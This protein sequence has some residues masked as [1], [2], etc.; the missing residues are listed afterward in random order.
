MQKTNSWILCCL[1][2][3]L[4]SPSRADVILNPTYVDSAAG[5]WNATRIAVFDQ[6]ISDWQS[7][8]S[9][10]DDGM[11][12]TMSVTIDFTA[13]F[14]NVANGYLG[15]WEGSGSFSSG[16]DIRP[17]SPGVSHT[18]RMNNFYDTGANTLWY[19]PTP[20][21][22]GSDKAFADW[23]ALTVARHEIGHLLGFTGFFVDD[24]NT[25]SESSPWTALIDGSNVFDPGGLNVA[26]E[27]GD[28]AHVLDDGLLMD[29]ALSNAE[30]RIAISAT[31]SQMLALAYGYQLN[32]VPE[33][34]ALAVV[35]CLATFA[36]VRRRQRF[37]EAK[38]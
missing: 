1:I 13:T 8:F 35:G 16:T 10:V 28:P 36:F 11:G 12:G 17:W 25:G 23:D 2:G 29:V 6:A 26:M 30:G 7:I 20:S 5:S 22:D 18:I 24:F 34:S 19:D 38:R 4:A 37:C 33:P 14:S 9:G 3:L 31:E 32:A 27:P 15:Q 21:D